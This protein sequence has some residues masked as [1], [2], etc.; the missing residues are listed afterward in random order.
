[1]KTHQY[2]SLGFKVPISIYNN[3]KEV[4]AAAGN[5]ED[6]LDEVNSNLVFRGTLPSARRLI[7][8]EVVKATGV[9]RKTKPVLKDGKPVLKDNVAVTAPDETEG[10]YVSRALAAKPS[11]DRGALQAAI[12]AAC[13]AKKLV[14]D[15]KEAVRV[16]KSATLNEKS[17][18]FITAKACIANGK[19]K[20]FAT[21]YKKVT[22]EDLSS[23]TDPI[24]VGLGIKKVAAIREQK[25]QEALVA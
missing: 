9:A 11:T 1:M 20:A 5:E 19:V 18:F 22:G 2:D 15:I 10:D 13:D 8:A 14:V 4:V 7:V 21:D 12:T 6:V 3:L 24:A 23:L 17:K 16:T 25:A